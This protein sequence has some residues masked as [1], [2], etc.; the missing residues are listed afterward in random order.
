ML[1]IEFNA[2]GIAT[3]TLTA[4]EV[5]HTD[6]LIEARK[7]ND[8]VEIAR[9]TDIRYARHQQVIAGTIQNRNDWKSFDRVAEIALQLTAADH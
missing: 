8:A 5:Y 3:N 7:A 2:A 9:I 1:Y 6:E 4:N